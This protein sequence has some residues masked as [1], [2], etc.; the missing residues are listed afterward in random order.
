MVIS[1]VAGSDLGRMPDPAV[2]TSLGLSTFTAVEGENPVIASLGSGASE[3]PQRDISP[4]PD[5]E[6]EQGTSSTNLKK[7]KDPN[8]QPFVF[9]EGFPPVPAKLVGVRR[10]GRAAEG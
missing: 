6:T 9:S 8:T 10:H 1:V 3:G 7:P 5:V 4:I 2:V